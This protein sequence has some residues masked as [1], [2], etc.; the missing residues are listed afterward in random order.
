V[1][2]VLGAANDGLAREYVSLA[3]RTHVQSLDLRALFSGH[4]AA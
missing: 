3:S 4:A 2:T 1:S